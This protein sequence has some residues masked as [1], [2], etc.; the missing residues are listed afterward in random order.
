MQKHPTKK[1][2]YLCDNPENIVVSFS[3]PD[4]KRRI[5]FG[6]KSDGGSA[7]P[8]SNDQIHILMGASQKTLF[9]KFFFLADG[10]VPCETRLRGSS[11][12]DFDDPPPIF[13]EDGDGQISIYTFE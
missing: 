2:T 8:V 13:P 12:G 3:P 1:R 7:I 5:V 6:F 11:G 9:V 4:T 10:A